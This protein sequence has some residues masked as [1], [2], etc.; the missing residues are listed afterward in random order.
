V[1]DS[2]AIE[3]A[4]DYVEQR[5]AVSLPFLLEAGYTARSAG[6]R[7]ELI[8]ELMTLPFIGI[9]A[10]TERRALQA[11][12]QLARAGH[13]RMP[14]VDVLLAALADRHRLGVL[15]YDADFDVVATVTHQPTEWAAPQGSL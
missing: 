5:L 2:R 10:E 14:P 4:E 11:Q 6:D 3:V 13:H 12:A 9:D 8:A 1:P 15:H 7:E